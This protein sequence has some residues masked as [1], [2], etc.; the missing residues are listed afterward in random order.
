[1]EALNATFGIDER[2]GSLRERR[3]GQQYIAKGHI[4][5]ERAE[6]NNHI[7]LHCSFGN[8]VVL[9]LVAQQDQRF[10]SAL[11]LSSIL[12]AHLRLGANDLCTHCICGFR[13]ITNACTRLLTDPI[14]QGQQA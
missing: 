11:H 12:A 4:R 8:G 5:F 14:G 3:N 10:E 6:R 2:T 7:G 13:K 9:W 1:M